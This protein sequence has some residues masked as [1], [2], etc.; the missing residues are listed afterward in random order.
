M[1]KVKDAAMGSEQAGLTG[2]KG[3]IVGN[4]AVDRSAS[5]LQKSLTAN[6]SALESN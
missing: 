1:I 3:S 5:S 6:Q 4:V 2:F